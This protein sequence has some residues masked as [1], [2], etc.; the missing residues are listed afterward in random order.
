MESVREHEYIRNNTKWMTIIRNPNEFDYF[1]LMIE[2]REIEEVN[3][4]T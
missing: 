1:D 2:D 4:S 3:L